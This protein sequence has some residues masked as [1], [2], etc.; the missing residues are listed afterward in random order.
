MLLL[1]SHIFHILSVTC[2][3]CKY[4]LKTDR[5]RSKIAM[6]G[7]GGVIGLER[8]NGAPPPKKRNKE[9]KLGS[10]YDKS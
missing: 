4:R 10:P 7:G 3:R 1:S 6:V 5:G 9:S 8:G 2:K